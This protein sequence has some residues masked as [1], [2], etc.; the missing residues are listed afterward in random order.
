[1]PL[2]PHAADWM[3]RAEIDYIGPFLKAWAAFNAWY[4]HSSG[5]TRERAM[6]EYVQSQPNSVRQGILPLLD[7]DNKTA[8]ALAFRQ[9]VYDL[10]Q[11]LDVIHFEVTH[12]DVN[13]RISLR[14]VR[15]QF[16]P[17]NNE[18]REYYRQEYKAV[19]VQDGAIEITVTSLQIDQVKFRHTQA[20]YDPKAVYDLP[21]FTA[22][23]SA[24][25]RTTL[26]Q[27]YDACNPRPMRDL[28]HGNGPVLTIAAMRFQCTEEDLLSGLVE[29]IYAMRNALFHGEVAPDEKVLACY[30]P[31]YR[32]VMQFLT[33]VR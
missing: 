2:P 23:L 11:S 20:Q 19:R 9:A 28:V 3:N 18:R 26:R 25:Q 14:T 12:N 22:N 32:I 27:F 7:N 21:D 16:K 10:H 31:A 24:R 5:Q 29:T 13:E 1:M 15:T 17:L 33:C 8:D 4:R 30:E 6:L